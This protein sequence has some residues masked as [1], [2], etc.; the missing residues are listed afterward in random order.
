M[1]SLVKKAELVSF[2]LET[3][4]SEAV[5]KEN[6]HLFDR[7]DHEIDEINFEHIAKL[8][9]AANFNISWVRKI[10]HSIK[11]TYNVPI[12][13]LLLNSL[14]IFDEGGPSQRDMCGFLSYIKMS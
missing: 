11:E 1:L 10:K 5:T 14:G 13:Q 4:H 9:K 8:C 6:L 12:K 7:I 3:V 2:K